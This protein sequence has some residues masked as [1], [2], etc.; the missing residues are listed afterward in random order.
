MV[1]PF[2]IFRS[3]LHASY[4]WSS[5]KA[6]QPWGHVLLLYLYHN[7]GSWASETFTWQSILFYMLYIYMLKYKALYLKP[8]KPNPALFILPH[9]TFLP[10]HFPFQIPPFKNWNIFFS[11][12]C[13][14]KYTHI[15]KLKALSW[16]YFY[17]H[18]HCSIVHSRQ[19]EECPKY[20]VIDEWIR[21][22]KYKKKSVE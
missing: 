17:S 13:T 14:Y 8:S 3:W 5:S 19:I 1:K 12:T 9:P 11:F 16:R 15:H 10:L 20:L 22:M 21:K 4:H 6:A 7:W 18:I 2:W